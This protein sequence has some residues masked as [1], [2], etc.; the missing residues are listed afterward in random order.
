MKNVDLK[1]VK[2]CPFCGSSNVK[3]DPKGDG[4]LCKSCLY[5]FAFRDIIHSFRDAK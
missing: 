2:F 5:L 4:F 1:R 3:R